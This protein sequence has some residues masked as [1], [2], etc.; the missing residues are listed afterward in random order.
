MIGGAACRMQAGVLRS[1]HERLADS[2]ARSGSRGTAGTRSRP[3]SP[4]RRATAPRR[5]GGDPP[6]ARLRPRHQGDRPPVRR[7]RLRRDL[8]EPLLPRGPG[9]G[10]GRRR[11]RP[12]G[13]RAACRT[14]GWSAT[15]AAR[16]PTC[17]AL[18]T[19]N[20]KVGVIGYCS[21]GRQ[22]VLAACNLDLDAAVDCYG[23]FVTGTPPEGFPLQ[24]EQPRR[25]AAEPALPAARPVRQRGQVP[26]ARAGRRARADPRRT[27]AR[28]TS[29][30]A[31]TTPGTPSSPS[32][33]RP[34]GSRRPTTAGNASPPSSPPTSGADACAPTPPSASPVE[35]S[36]KGPN[37]GW[38]RVT[39]ATVYF[40]HPVHAMAE[41]TL[42]IDL[43]ALRRT[44]RPPGSRSS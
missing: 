38:F 2:D 7:A 1:D 8:P 18:P 19:S 34:T 39:D 35:G 10:P 26:L 41:H 40:D 29:S 15:S 31:T 11:G 28:P 20:G 37:G 6:H 13:P 42:N 36:A 43:A 5:R 16:R 44:G 33:G 22:S 9:R 32:T 23:A 17:A 24:V 14:S 3:T 30:T 25:P 21:G 4:R 12:R 27:T